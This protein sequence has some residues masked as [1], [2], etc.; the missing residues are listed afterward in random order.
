MGADDC[1][2]GLLSH[3]REQGGSGDGAMMGGGGGG[4]RRG[5][6]RK[7]GRKGEE[8]G[9]VERGRRREGEHVN[10]IPKKKVSLSISSMDLKPV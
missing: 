6:K 9:G 5:E 4:G 3:S 7:R 10:T 2:N 1:Q 8:G